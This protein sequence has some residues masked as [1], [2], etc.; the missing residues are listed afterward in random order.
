MAS[1]RTPLSL[2]WRTRESSGGIL[3]P[4]RAFGERMS[5]SP[6]FSSEAPLGVICDDMGYSRVP[7][8]DLLYDF[9]SI[10]ERGGGYQRSGEFHRYLGERSTRGCFYAGG[11]QP[12]CAAYARS[13]SL[14]LSTS[15][16]SSSVRLSATSSMYSRLY[17][18]YTTDA[19][20]AVAKEPK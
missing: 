16:V 1:C 15:L 14:V 7:S 2:Q 5:S 6:M 12:L 17:S 19:S 3:V 10:K 4:L 11:V 8:E 20:A 13:D 18:L 9:V